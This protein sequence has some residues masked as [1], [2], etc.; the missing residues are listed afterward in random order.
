MIDNQ[1]GLPCSPDFKNPNRKCVVAKNEQLTKINILLF[2]ILST[3]GPKNGLV[4][5]II[6]LYNYEYQLLNK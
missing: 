6:K 1:F 5:A 3:N 4:I 2:P